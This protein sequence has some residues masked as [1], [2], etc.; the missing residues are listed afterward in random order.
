MTD[1]DEHVRVLGELLNWVAISR[2]ERAAL[3]AAIAAL[4]A[5]GWQPIESAPVSADYAKEAIKFLAHWPD[6]RIEV[7]ISRWKTFGGA[8]QVKLDIDFGD[9]CIQH[10]MP[11]DYQ[12]THWM[13]LPPPK[14]SK[15]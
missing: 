9:T 3:T 5:T 11:P 14:E 1:N 6:G 13:P 7:V 2:A 8:P 4:K 15:R 10:H 12:P